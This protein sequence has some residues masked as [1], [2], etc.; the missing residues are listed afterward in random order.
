[1]YLRNDIRFCSQMNGQSCRAC[2]RT[3]T[4]KHTFLPILIADMEMEVTHRHRDLDACNRGCK[5]KGSQYLVTWGDLTFINSF[6]YVTDDPRGIEKKLVIF[7]DRQTQCHDQPSKLVSFMSYPLL[8]SPP[9]VS[10]PAAGAVSSTIETSLSSTSLSS[11]ST[12]T[13]LF[14]RL[15]CAATT[16]ASSS[17]SDI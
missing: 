9:P 2:L 14:F 5:R 4:P 7:E 1:M 6:I 8:Q 17:S 10:L 16:A 13:A 15:D 11:S 3:S 12:T